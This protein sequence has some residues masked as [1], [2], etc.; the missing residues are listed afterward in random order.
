M[1]IEKIENQYF[2]GARFDLLGILPGILAARGNLAGILAGI[3]LPEEIWQGFW[4]ESGCPR[5]FGRD[6]G[7][8]LAAR[9]NL[10]GIVGWNLAGPGKL[11]GILAGIW[12]PGE[13]W[14]GFWPGFW[15]KFGLQPKPP[16][17]TNFH[18]KDLKTSRLE[19]LTLV[20]MVWF[21]STRDLGLVSY[22]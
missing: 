15:L 6:F 5:K 9:G 8:N 1:Y 2:Y 7:W 10:A 20:T 17:T 12:L 21:I 14:P 19:F 13:I 11:A 18:L 4:L 22:L 3:W 16:R